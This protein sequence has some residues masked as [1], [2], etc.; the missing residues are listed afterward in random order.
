[1][2]SPISGKEGR[3]IADALHIKAG[4]HKW[5]KAD[6][7]LP[8][9]NASGSEVL[10]AMPAFQLSPCSRLSDSNGT[11]F[12]PAKALTRRTLRLQR[13]CRR[14]SPLRIS[15]GRGL[16]AVAPVARPAQ[17]VDPDPAA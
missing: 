17:D 6:S 9:R 10:R 5:P 16:G 7:F 11:S 12:G 4:R 15:P 2:A 14:P 3:E 8:P 13:L 1:M